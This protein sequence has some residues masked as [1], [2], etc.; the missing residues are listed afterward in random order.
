MKATQPCPVCGSNKLG[1]LLKTKDFFLT[2]EDFELYKCKNCDYI[3]TSP[4]PLGEELGKYYNSA[5]YYSH[6]AS[7]KGIINRIY[8]FLRK[9]NIKNKFSLIHRYKSKGSILDIGC[10]TG[11]LLKYFSE[12]DWVTQGIEPNEEARNFAQKTYQLSV[13]D[14]A[15]INSLKEE[16][17]DVVTMWHVLEHVPDINNRIKQIIQILK[18]KGTIFIALPNIN[19]PD[20]IKYGKYWAGLDVPRHLHHFSPI[21]FSALANKHSLKIVE[22]VPMKMDAYYVSLLSEKYKKNTLPYFSAIY[23][24]LM[25][26]FQ[27]RKTNN[28]SSMIF[29][30]KKL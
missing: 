28:Y 8:G 23:A 15:A 19:S 6:S 22:M 4:V 26:N 24:G 14:E 9:I 12:H 1:S 10:G 16:S 30:L 17:F 18:P 27:A 21:S 13:K 20:S 29:V 5:E 2:Q 7:K 11:E 3:Y 25:S